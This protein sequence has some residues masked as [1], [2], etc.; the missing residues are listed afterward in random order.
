MLLAGIKF[1]IGFCLGISVFMA[2][3]MVIIYAASWISRLLR[4]PKSRPQMKERTPSGVASKR[5]STSAFCKNGTIQ[6]FSFCS[7]VS[8]EGREDRKK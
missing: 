2:L 4:K 1:G 7:V 5:T 8:W 6:S 3:V